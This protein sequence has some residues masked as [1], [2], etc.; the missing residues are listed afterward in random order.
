VEELDPNKHMVAANRELEYPEKDYTLDMSQYC[1]YAFTISEGMIRKA[2]EITGRNRIE[3]SKDREY[4]TY[5]NEVP[6]EI[7]IDSDLAW[8]L[9]IWFAE[10]SLSTRN[11]VPVGIRITMPS[12]ERILVEKWLSIINSKFNGSGTLSESTVARGGKT[13]CWINGNVSGKHLG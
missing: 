9:G 2:H 7:K 3:R 1:P 4:V 6:A 5:Y 8:A 11:G 12:E 10:G 13:N